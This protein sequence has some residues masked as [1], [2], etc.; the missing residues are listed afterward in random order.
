M[1]LLLS[2]ESS[3]IV[4]E[5]TWM[6]LAAVRDLRPQLRL[7]TPEEVEG[8]EQD[9]LAEFVMARASAGITDATIRGDVAA[10][11]EL[12][13]WFGRP[14]WQLAP[15]D[16]DKFF[17]RDQREKASGTKVRKA[18]AF[19][20]YFEFLELRHQPG[21]HAATGFVVESPLDEVNR[22]RGG[23]HS[24]LRIPPTGR[25]VERLFTGWRSDMTSARK[26]APAARN[27]TALRL[28]SLIGPRVSELCLL[29]TGDVCWELGRF[30]KVLL[31][32]KGSRG[33]GKKDR[34]VPL[35][36][37]SRDL[38]EWWV[39]GPRWEFDDRVNDPASPLFPSER[40]HGD[41]S[42]RPVTDDALRNGLTEAVAAHL[43]EQVGRL[44]PHLLRHY[45]ASDL[46][47][48]GMDVV[49]IQEILGHEWINTTMIYV[50]PRELHQMGEKLQVAC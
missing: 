30:G 41:G 15:K 44:A 48:N 7:E 27:Y 17:G 14:L 23:T 35:I 18:A 45:A 2:M 36:N 50:N 25:E 4:E 22:P 5:G 6:T 49:S 34:L 19:A 1:G 42:S 10:V 33:R 8:F 47:L 43:P 31:H 20:V 38:L 39:S 21:I 29:T 13:E 26:Y 11:I 16:L 28:A 9:L 24:R 46:Y 37:G 40:R 12:R 32:G 3:V